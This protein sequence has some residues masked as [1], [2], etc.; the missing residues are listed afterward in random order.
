M[1][2]Y[3]PRAFLCVRRCAVTGSSVVYACWPLFCVDCVPFGLSYHVPIVI[4]TARQSHKRSSSSLAFSPRQRSVLHLSNLNI[5]DEL[6]PA[7]AAAGAAS[8]NTSAAFGFRHPSFVSQVPSSPTGAASPARSDD[9]GDKMTYYAQL[10]APDPTEAIAPPSMTV[11]SG[12]ISPTAAAAKRRATTSDLP[13][14]ARDDDDEADE[15]YDRKR[16]RE[17][18][19]SAAFTASSARR[20]RGLQVSAV[21]C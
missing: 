16:E 19:R 10:S 7:A 13:S 5:D 2:V 17:L 1:Y 18:Q 3:V 12:G 20:P 14:G 6:P 4:L 21:E 9:S 15:A 8:S 11:E